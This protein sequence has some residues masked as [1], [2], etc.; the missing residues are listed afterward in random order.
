[1][2]GCHLD[3][4]NLLDLFERE[5]VTLGAGVPTIWL[6]LQEA[7]EKEPKRWKLEPKLRMIVGGAAAPE[8]MLRA[9]DKLGIEL[10]HA[11]GMTE[12]SPLGTVARVPPSLLD[13]GEDERYRAR[14]KQGPPVPFVDVRARG[15]TGLVPFDGKT[16][17]ELEV[18]GAWVASSYYDMPDAAS[19]WTPDGWFKTGDVVTIEPDGTIKITDRTKDLIKSGGEWISSVDLEN[20]LMGHPAVREAAVIAVPNEKWS[21]RPLACV[22]L[23]AE[24]KASS[25][26]LRAF[27]GERFPKFWIPEAVEFL[28]AIPRTSAGK[29]QKSELRERFKG[30]WSKA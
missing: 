22:V 23:K 19:R 3:A 24:A 7:L 28:E 30:L 5:R 18:R 10:I 8:S 1:M 12:M 17:G 11:W 9:Y 21:E 27:L 2:P 6:G 29:F 16:P 14:A 15:D 20:A 26:E 25:D 13:K 4:P